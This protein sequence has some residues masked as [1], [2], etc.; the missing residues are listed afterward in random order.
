[1]GGRSGSVRAGVKSL[2]CARCGATCETIW[3][4]SEGYL[5]VVCRT[6]LERSPA[7]VQ[8][9]QEA[10]RE[11]HLERACPRCGAPLGELCI[12]MTPTLQGRSLNARHRLKR[13]HKE[14]LR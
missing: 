7:A 11:A 10:K 6:V 5:C 13:A 12:D 1:M 4:R 14:R 9:Y 8:R 2:D 3:R